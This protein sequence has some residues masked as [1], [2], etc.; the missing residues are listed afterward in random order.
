MD[1]GHRYLGMAGVLVFLGTGVYLATGFPELHGG[2]AGIR[3]Q[4]RANHAY[5]LLSSLLN[6]QVGIHFSRRAEGWRR[7]LQRL[8]SALL[9][10]A[11]VVLVTAF[12]VEPPRGSPQRPITTLGIVLLLGGTV[13]HALARGRR[14]R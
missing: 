12:F 7:G 14:A 1:A 11:P 8:G 10:A 6:W 5:I 4:F 2:D 9:L 3:F 13:L